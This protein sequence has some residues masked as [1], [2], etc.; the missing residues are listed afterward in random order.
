MEKKVKR[1]VV[2]KTKQ[3]LSKL[4]TTSFNCSQMKLV[5]VKAPEL[6]LKANQ[7]M[8]DEHKQS[9]AGIS[10]T[11]AVIQEIG[12]AFTA[13]GTVVV[14]ENKRITISA[15]LNGRIEKLYFQNPD[16]KLREGQAL[17]DLY[18]EEL[19]AAEKDYLLSLQ[20][21]EKPS[22]YAETLQK[23]RDAS[24]NKLLLWGL[25]EKQIH[26]IEKSGQVSPLIK[27]YASVSG[28]VTEILVK[29]GQYVSEGTPLFNV[30]DLSSV[31]VEGQL[32]PN[33]VQYL[34]KNK[35][36]KVELEIL[37]KEDF[38]AEMVDEKPNLESNS[39]V[40]MVRWKLEN[41]TLRIKPGMMAYIHIQKGS[42]KTLTIPKSALI[43]GKMISAWVEIENNI[44]ENRMVTTGVEDE[45]NVEILSGIT[46]G[47]H[48]VIS[49]VY[50]LN[51]EYIFK[52]GAD[53]MAGMKM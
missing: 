50:L 45:K 42:K 4:P 43:H 16:D 40:N 20:Q 1:K 53:P 34:L 12:P 44:F 32:Y 47:E 52:T 31:W 14:D 33:E 9:L 3:K 24:K 27:I 46:A 29:E 10:T 2:A 8:L 39:I 36:A 23:I 7:L 18:S 15:R 13:T 38:K 28:I 11:E 30:A 5:K 48:V 37:P 35:H 17:Y 25:S 49:G 22:G 41:P 26:D 6:T 51:S 21:A 19:L